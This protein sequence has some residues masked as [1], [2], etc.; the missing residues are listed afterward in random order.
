MWF[1]L[2]YHL[3][4]RT[5]LTPQSVPAKKFYAF[6]PKDLPIPIFDGVMLE[7]PGGGVVLLGGQTSP[8][9][10]AVTDVYNVYTLQNNKWFTLQQPVRVPR[11]TAVAFFVPDAITNCTAP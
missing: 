3:E 8:A 10:G 7:H 2:I 6:G 11:R 5:N 9:A 1:K 4:S